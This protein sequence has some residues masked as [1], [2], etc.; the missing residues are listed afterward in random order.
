MAG[1]IGKFMFADFMVVLV[2]S[3]QPLTTA[4][5]SSSRPTGIYGLIIAVLV[6]LDIQ[7][8]TPDETTGLLLNRYTWDAGFRHFWSGV[9]IGLS[10][11][12]GGYAI[13]EVGDKGQKYIGVRPALFVPSILIVSFGG[14]VTLYGLIGSM[15]MIS[16]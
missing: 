16:G 6:I 7:E 4:F 3:F 13:G 14:A 1:V 5:S 11:I 15:I 9:C 2:V 10:G 8:P 12:A